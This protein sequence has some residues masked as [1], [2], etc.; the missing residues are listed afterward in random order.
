MHPY[1]LYCL[2]NRDPLNGNSQV[3]FFFMYASSLLMKKG[4]F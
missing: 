2:W 4:I 1:F 3:G